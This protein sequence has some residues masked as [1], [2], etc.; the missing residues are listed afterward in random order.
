MATLM[1]HVL[2]PDSAAQTTVPAGKIFYS[3][4]IW[5]PANSP[6]ILS[7]S[8]RIS[9]SATLIIQPGV[10]VNCHGFDDADGGIYVDGRLEAQSCTFVGTISY[11][12][13]LISFRTGSSGFVD[14]CQLSFTTTIKK[15]GVRIESSNAT[16][17]NCILFNLNNALFVAS[18]TPTIAGNSISALSRGLVNSTTSLV[19]AEQNWWSSPSGP[20][21]ATLNPSGTGCVVFGNVDF[22]PWLLSDPHVP[23]VCGDA[24]GDA[25]V[26]IS[27]A[28]YLIAYIFSGGPAPNP[29]AA[30]DANCDAAVDISDAVYLIGYIFSGG[31]APCNSCK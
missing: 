13:Q 27:D 19:M 29:L 28:V 3:N 22:V 11:F 14:D 18:G 8:I 26:D 6:Y 31:P 30:G 25:A 10:T 16:V 9:A 2:I 4:E 5:S 17:S 12:S 23:Y 7:G 24:N 20:F 21:H 15:D 1:I